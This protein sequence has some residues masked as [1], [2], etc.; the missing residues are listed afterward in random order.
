MLRVVSNMKNSSALISTAMLSALFEEN[1]QD[2]IALLTPFVIKIIYEDNTVNENDIVDKMKNKYSFNNFPHAIIKIIINRLKRQ[3][4][5]KQEQGKYL[6]LLNVTNIVKEFDDRH[7]KSKKE[8][9]EVI[10][11]LMDY[12]KKNTN[13][14]LNYIDCRN[15][16]AKF[17]DQNGYL[18]YED[19]E[20]S[21]RINKNIDNITYHIGRC[22]YE[23]IEKQDVIYMY[24]VNII[25][26]ALIA[27]ALYVNIDNDNK[28]DLKKLNCFFDT[29]FMLRVLDLKLPDENKSALELVNLL[30]N[31]NVKIKCFKHNYDEIENILEEYIKNFGKPQEKTLENLILQ[32]Y[33][34]TEVRHLLNSLDTLFYNLGIEIVDTPEYDKK[35][36]KYVI[37]EKKLKENLIGV[38]KNKN[39]SIKKIENDVKSVSSIMRLRDGKEYRKLEDCNAIF[40]TTNKDIRVE[41]NKLLNLD[42][43]F[44]I[45]PVVSDIDLTAIVWLKSLINNK[46]LPELKLTENAMAAIKPSTTLRKRFAQSL[47]NLK[48]SKTNVTSETL[49]NLLCSNYFVE[50]LMIK[51][52]GD[53]QKI[54]PNVLL[55]TYEETLKQ[56]KLLNDQELQINKEN[57]NLI[58]QLLEKEERDRRYRRNVYDKY[59]KIENSIIYTIKIMEKFLK[60]IICLLLFY[61]CYRYTNKETSNPLVS[62]LLF[63]LGVYS[64]LCNFVPISVFQLFDIL[65]RKINNVLF[66]KINRY[67]NNKAE[68]E[69][70]RIFTIK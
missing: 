32:N 5:I 45:S 9:E 18:L 7:E 67:Y 1:K 23:H 54:N 6:F 35:K 21:T 33:S 17:L 40:V 22:I 34:E 42:T 69:I 16:F 24:L 28:T 51:V 50:N 8:I 4:I 65:F 62:W 15:S 60:L 49:Y 29:P 70:E 20:N 47:S 39:T 52:N 11:D 25:E 30:K 10:K 19:I 55:N 36:Y 41:T 2:N 57:E 14:K 26:G 56:N 31:L 59:T 53:V 13:I 37:D 61:L 63:I 64:L 68:K 46:N 3:Q 27:N 44:K 58:N 66:I 48:T 43:N 12:F 38:Y